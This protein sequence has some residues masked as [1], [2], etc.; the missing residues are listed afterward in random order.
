MIL[1]L[2]NHLPGRG[3]TDI[4]ANSVPLQIYYKYIVTCPNKIPDPGIEHD[5]LRPEVCD[6]STTLCPHIWFPYHCDNQVLFQS[7]R[8]QTCL[9]L[10]PSTER[11]QQYGLKTTAVQNCEF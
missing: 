9:V 6:L 11:N 7:P 3:V 1:Q 5:P 8:Q 2:H 10:V 4:I